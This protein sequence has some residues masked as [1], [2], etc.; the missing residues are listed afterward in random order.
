MRRFVPALIAGLAISVSTPA[1]AESDG[2]FGLSLE[3]SP[4][5][6]PIGTFFDISITAPTGA[7]VVL[8]FSDSPGPTQ[9]PF[10]EVCVGSPFSAFPLV[11][12]AD[13]I[14]FDHFIPCLP[15]RIGDKG[16]FQFVAFHASLPGGQGLSNSA[17]VEII[18]GD[19]A[20]V[21][22]PGDFVS[23]TQGGWGQECSGNNVGCLRD[24]HFG[25]VFPMGL[26]LGDAGGLD[27][28]AFYAALFGSSMA[29]Q[30]FLPAGGTPDVFNADLTD[31]LVTSAGVF[32]GQ[33]AATS[34]NVG[35]DAAGVFDGMKSDPSI[36]LADLV[37]I[38]NVHPALLG[39][40]VAE[41]LELAHGVISGE[42]AA[43]VVIDDQMVTIS[44]ISSALDA[45]NNDFVGGEEANGTLGISHEA[46]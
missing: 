2:Q 46:S 7:F 15:E 39:M 30:S 23:Y 27:G 38:A 8:L 12:P 5:Q 4:G 41:V 16:Y 43:P 40:T 21:P 29:V 26:L 10:G 25:G 18:D 36:K 3:L 17:C 11:M 45:V 32:A 24:T 20:I 37:F 35:F 9:T 31:P 33:L 28:D 44:D 22:D 6:V 14:M 34:L 13:N 19:C 1:L 42:V